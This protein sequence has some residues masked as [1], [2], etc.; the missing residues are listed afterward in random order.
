[1]LSA[2]EILDP[3][4]YEST[5]RPLLEAETL[6]G[7]C[8]TS[9][10][11]YQREVEGIFLKTWNFIGRVDRVPNP[12]DYFAFEFVGVP[13]VVLRDNEGRVRAFANTCRHRGAKIACGEGNK[14]NLSCPYH[15]WTYKLDGTLD[16]V[17]EMDQAVGFDKSNYNL[18]ELRL[19]TWAGFLF[20]NF[21]KEA[22]PLAAHLGDLP[23]LMESYGFERMRCTRRAEYQLAC[24]W[25]VYV[26]NAMESYHVPTV[27]LKTLQ[28]QKR[29]HNPPILPERGEFSGLFTRHEGSRAL[30]PGMKGFPFIPTLKGDAAAGTYYI[31]INPSTMFG[32][33]YDCMWWL[34]L[35]PEGPGQSKLIVGSCFP[36]DTVARD[37]FEEL[38]QNYYRRLDISIAEDN[39]ISDQQQIGLSSP[40]CLPGRFSHM[41]PLV[42]VID[43][44]VL[45]RVIGAA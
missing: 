4:L 41:E 39:E 34:E 23:A 8:Y 5:R 36:E 10:A 40:F 27:H 2:S 11:F 28:Q 15:S 45:D 35:H 42:H 20:L 33:T 19:E 7:H 18:I 13:V 14:K 6:P 30:L 24:N 29:D 3:R 1:M 31:L 44:W 43:N 9:E 16:F 12:G 32:C 22:V 26:E 21:D 37:D 25:K 38:V 17:P